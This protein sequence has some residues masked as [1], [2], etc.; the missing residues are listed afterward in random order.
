M[1]RK[2]AI[3]RVRLAALFNIAVTFLIY[4][5]TEPHYLTP[6]LVYNSAYES[7]I[8]AIIWIRVVTL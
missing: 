2:I 8:I 4:A 7:S 6:E 1:L 3:A 5:C